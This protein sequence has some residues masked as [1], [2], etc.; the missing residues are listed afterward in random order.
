MAEA[1]GFGLLGRRNKNDSAE[2]RAERQQKAIDLSITEQPED[3][4]LEDHPPSYATVTGTSAA[5]IRRDMA[6]ATST[7]DG[8]LHF[9]FEVWL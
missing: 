1:L 2:E 8:K 6:M 7:Y 3:L 5:R 9:T 4:E